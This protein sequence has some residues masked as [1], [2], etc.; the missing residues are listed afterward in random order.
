MI[1]AFPIIMKYYKLNYDHKS[2]N[3]LD[4]VMCDS[5]N[6]SQKYDV[7]SFR[8]G[9]NVLLEDELVY[10]FNPNK[11]IILT[12][13]LYNVNDW[14]IISLRAKLL[15]EELLAN[16]M[17][18]LPINIK[19]IDNKMIYNYFIL[20]ITSVIEDAIDLEKSKYSVLH[21]DN[22]KW[23]CFLKYVLKKEKIINHDFFLLKNQTVRFCSERVKDI[24][25]KNNFSGFSFCEI[26]ISSK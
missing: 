17:Q 20:N 21:V 18:F 12:D 13:F 25:E 5:F 1:G 19:N 22:I 14:M 2:C 11:G 26:E 7:L 8:K 23:Q 10:T 24:V 16:D 4:W 3:S 9:E 6:N 15:F